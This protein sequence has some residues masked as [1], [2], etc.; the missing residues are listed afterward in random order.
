M[1]ERE[2]AKMQEFSSAGFLVPQILYRSER[3]LVLSDAGETVE[4]RLR[5]L[6]GSRLHAARSLL[7]NCAAE[8]GKVHMLGLYHGRPHP[9]DM[10]VCGDRIGFLDFE[11]DPAAVMPLPVAQARDIFLLLLQT[12][13][14]V[15][16]LPKSKARCCWHGKNTP[17]KR[18][19]MSLKMCQEC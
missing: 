15:V 8:V 2:A 13:D 3:G 4:K 17:R 11:E 6:G 1:I 9:R 18:H 16:D 12:V 5:R 19:C 14:D 10:F 7:V